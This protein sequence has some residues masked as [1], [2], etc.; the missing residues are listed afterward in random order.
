MRNRH[1]DICGE[2]GD[3]QKN[4]SPCREASSDG[5]QKSEA[6]GN[7]GDAADGHDQRGRRQYRRNDTDVD[8]EDD[9]M[10]YA[11]GDEKN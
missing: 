11:G 8:S 1:I 10:H 2:N 5:K 7:F 4:Q 9:K 6:A 3:Q